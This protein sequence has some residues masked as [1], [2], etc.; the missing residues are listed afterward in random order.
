ML[1]LIVINLKAEIKES[2]LFSIVLL[3]D[4]IPAQEKLLCPLLE[5]LTPTF[6][7]NGSAK[8]I[9][10]EDY[11][12][13]LL[14]LCKRAGIRNYSDCTDL[15]CFNVTGDGRQDVDKLGKLLIEFLHFWL[16]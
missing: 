9:L 15:L 4:Q 6:K 8:V 12:K 1:I 3:L 16:E 2:V 5:I 11:L 7:G 10:T 14:G 13:K